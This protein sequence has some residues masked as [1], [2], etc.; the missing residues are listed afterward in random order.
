[1]KNWVSYLI[2]LMLQS[3]LSLQQLNFAIVSEVIFH[4]NLSTQEE[5]ETHQFFELIRVSSYTI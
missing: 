3:D 4:E 1:M 5:I 2:M